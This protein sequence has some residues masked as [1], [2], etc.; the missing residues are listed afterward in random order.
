MRWGGLC[1]FLLFQLFGL[2]V[3]NPLIRDVTNDQ[4]IKDTNKRS[5]ILAIWHELRRTQNPPPTTTTPAPKAIDPVK[6]KKDL[7]ELN[8]TIRKLRLVWEM[9]LIWRFKANKNGLSE[10]R[11]WKK[12]WT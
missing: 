10:N 11:V 6:L 9:S 8:L 7:K 12:V 1:V 5:P 4:P 3:T 2:S